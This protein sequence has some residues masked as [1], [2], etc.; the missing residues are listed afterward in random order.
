MGICD[1]RLSVRG[2]GG[3]LDL[4]LTPEVGGGGAALQDLTRTISVY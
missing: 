3:Y 2:T 1:L 4:Q